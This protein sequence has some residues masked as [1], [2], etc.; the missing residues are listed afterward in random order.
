[1]WDNE[2]GSRGHG[3]GTV[4]RGGGVSEEEDGMEMLGCQ[5]T[6]GRAGHGTVALGAI[7]EVVKAV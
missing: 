5:C 7:V 4:S 3:T 6:G 1:M 2:V